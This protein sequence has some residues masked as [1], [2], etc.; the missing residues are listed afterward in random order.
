MKFTLSPWQKAAP[1]ALLLTIGV[2][3]RADAAAVLSYPSAEHAIS[4][5]VTFWWVQDPDAWGYWL[6]LVDDDGVV[7]SS[8]QVHGANQSNTVIQNI[9]AGKPLT[10]ELITIYLDGNNVTNW[11]TRESIRFNAPAAQVIAPLSD[12][13]TGSSQTF[14]WNPV[15]GATAYYWTLTD[16]F[17]ATWFSHYVTGQTEVTLE[18]LPV[19][20]RKLTSTLHTVVENNWERVSL[21][22]FTTGSE[23]TTTPSIW[24]P[25]PGT[26]W[27]WQLSGQI[28][29]AFDVQMYDI[30]LFDAPQSVI[31]TLK[32]DGRKVI[33]YFSAGSSE[34]WRPDAAS[35]P[36][37]VQGRN[38][39]WAG[40][41]WLDIRAI[42]ALAPVMRAR[43]D[44]AVSKGCDGVEPDN[45]DGYSNNTGFSMTA[46]DQLVFNRWLA[47]EAHLRGLSIGL[48][49]DVDQIVELEPWFDW[50]LNEQC[51][52]FDECDLMSPFTDAGKAVFGVEYSGNASNFCPE[53]N[54]LNFD[55]LIKD[56]DLT[57][58]FATCR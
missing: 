54:A 11:D 43:L 30:D 28:N 10:A 18:G 23:T 7:Y 31:N 27:Q 52:E 32:A 29:T 25:A 50:A 33:C 44:L 35:V 49:N 12:S 2:Q 8:Y 1:L 13:L 38:N 24:Q 5:D 41:K 58:T 46:N 21:R 3:D 48:K 47:E 9:P 56:L 15:Q 51:A 40:E 6:S 4:G 53:I 16:E 37:S 45:V 20:G 34:N 17:G 39:G 42:D 55:W 57:D 26:T 22:E 36:S 14:S 19:D